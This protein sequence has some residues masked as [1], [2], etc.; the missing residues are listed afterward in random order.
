MGRARGKTPRPEGRRRNVI[1]RSIAEREIEE[2]HDYFEEQR[3]GLGEDFSNRLRVLFDLLR[4][5]PLAFAEVCR[6]VRRANVRRFHYS[7][8]YAVRSDE[9][10]VLG[11]IQQRR[12][13]G[14]WQAR[15]RG[16]LRDNP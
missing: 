5:T 10:V 15:V 11:V 14:V 1:V 9:V 6:G 3:Q 12:H 16:W 7:V 13:P 4:V 2:A 8:Y